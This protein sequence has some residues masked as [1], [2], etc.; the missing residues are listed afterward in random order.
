MYNPPMRKFSLGQMMI[1][2]AMAAVG[3]R[4]IVYLNENA[5]VRLCRE[6]PAVAW[7]L[8]FGASALI[9]GAVLSLCRRPVLGAVVGMVLQG[10]VLFVLVRW[11]GV[12][13]P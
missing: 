1:C 7:L 12:R 2:V 4:V 5:G 9:G 11:F 10:V 13:F 8:L 6:Y 3:S